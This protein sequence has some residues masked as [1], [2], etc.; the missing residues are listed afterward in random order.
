MAEHFYLLFDI[1]KYIFNLFAKYL[2]RNIFQIIFIYR[3]YWQIYCRGVMVK[4]M[5]V[6][7]VFKELIKK[8]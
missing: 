8:K 5:K 6:E 7:I 3:I 4:A 2:Y 1:A